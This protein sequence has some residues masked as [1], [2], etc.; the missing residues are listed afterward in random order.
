MNE[1]GSEQH[2]LLQKGKAKF[3]QNKIKIGSAIAIV[4]WLAAG[5]YEY[6][7]HQKKE[8]AFTTKAPQELVGKHIHD[9][10]SY[11]L[12]LDGDTSTIW[13]S[14]YFQPQQ[15]IQALYARKF[16]RP[17]QAF[18]DST[19]RAVDFNDIEPVSLEQYWESIQ[20]TVCLIQEQFDWVKFNQDTYEDEPEKAVLFKNICENIDGNS[21]LAYSMTEL[22]P[23]ADGAF[24]KDFLSFLLQYWGTKFIEFLPAIYDDLASFGPYQFT[25]LAISET[26]NGKA[27]ASNMNPYLPEKSRIPG[28]VV[29]LKWDDHHKAAYLFAMYN[30]WT[31]LENDRNVPALKLLTL[32]EYRNDLTQLI[33]IMH[34]MPAYWDDFLQEWYRLNTNP[35]YL[36]KKTHNKDHKRIYE[37]D[38]NKNHKIDLY[39]SKIKPHLSHNYG[40]KTYFNRKAL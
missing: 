39:E 16:S 34:N 11:Y 3:H 14:V 31:L 29:D 30:I 8:P 7:T 37:Y 36:Y 25:Y 38:T 9:L 35:D 10:Y 20:N 13:D 22:F 6:E 33:A 15:I 1:I 24:N 5:V 17:A 28:N 4:L 26:K 12:G 23:N 40:M 32:P 2:S 18:Y 27:W 21:L 19:V